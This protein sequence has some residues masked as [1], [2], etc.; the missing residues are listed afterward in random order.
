M[1]GSRRA[2]GQS[3]FCGTRPVAS[4]LFLLPLA[5]LAAPGPLA[6]IPD[7]LDTG[8]FS[9][10]ETRTLSLTLKNLGSEPVTLFNV[11][12]TC[13]CIAIERYPQ[14]IPPHGSGTLLATIPPYALA[15]P[16]T[17]H[18]HL[19]TSAEGTGASLQI[20]VTGTARPLFSTTCR[21]E[22]FL[23]DPPPGTLWRGDFVIETFLP[24]F[25]LAACRT[26]EKGTAASAHSLTVQT[27]AEGHVTFTLSRSVTFSAEPHQSS[28]LFVDLTPPAGLPVPPPIPL[29]VEALRNKTLRLIPASLKIPYALTPIRRQITLLPPPKPETAA[30]DTLSAEA[31]LDGI[32]VT[33]TPLPAK[34]GYRMTLDLT[35]PAIET[36]HR[37]GSHPIRIRCN[38][39]TA[40]VVITPFDR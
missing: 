11:V 4:L 29:V 14:T 26:V 28:T 22:T 13:D 38:G 32:S 24:G 9:A 16:F 17:R 3:A 31:G 37:K 36:I 25:S 19:T 23:T 7:R 18:I 20:P 35:Q 1:P 15:G 6:C 5:T 30:S 34:N 2:R 40:E 10:A 33:F 27:N 12:S 8:T 39:E 21:Q